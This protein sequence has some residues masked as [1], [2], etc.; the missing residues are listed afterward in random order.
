MATK[1]AKTKGKA[2]EGFVSA[3]VKVEFWKPTEEGQRVRGWYQGMRVLPA[4]RGYKEQT[5]FDVADENGELIV[6]T[7]ASLPRQ[8]ERVNE[9]D[10]VIVTF[11]GR[12]AMS[13]GKAPMKD[14]TVLVK[15]ELRPFKKNE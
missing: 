15:G 8:F 10:E 11:E 1:A 7:G 4:K 5:V 13:D 6:L 14:F 9:G 2:E 12:V 3:N